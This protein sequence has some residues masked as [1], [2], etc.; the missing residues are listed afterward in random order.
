MCVVCVSVCE[1]AHVCSSTR[2][3]IGT[4]CTALFVGDKCQFDLY[5]HCTP[6]ELLEQVTVSRIH[7]SWTKFSKKKPSISRTEYFITDA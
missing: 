5:I 6:V 4:V 7:S 2:G 3:L 1:L